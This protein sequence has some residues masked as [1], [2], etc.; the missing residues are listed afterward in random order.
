MTTVKLTTKLLDQMIEEEY[1]KLLME[2]QSKERPTLYITDVEGKTIRYEDTEEHKEF[3]K[4]EKKDEAIRGFQSYYRT[5]NHNQAYELRK[6]LTKTLL[7]DLSLSQI[8][9][10]TSRIISATKGFTMPVDKNKK[11]K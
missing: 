9:E 1:E 11:P 3:V 2:N 5:L 8:E 10:I 6:W 7:N 4:Q